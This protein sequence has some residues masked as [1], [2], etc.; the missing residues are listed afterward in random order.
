MLMRKKAR[1]GIPR[2]FMEPR[3]L[4]AEKLG[5]KIPAELKESLGF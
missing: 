4:I 2:A 3:Y 1:E 5:Y